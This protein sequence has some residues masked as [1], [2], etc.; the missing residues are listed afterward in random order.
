MLECIPAELATLVSAE[1]Q[2]PTIGIGAGVGCDGQVQVFHDLLGLG[3]DFLPRH[4]RRYADIGA[5]V[6]EAIAAYADDV[7]GA[8]FPGEEQTTHMDAG[9]LESVRAA[10]G[11][12]LRRV[13]GSGTEA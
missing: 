11:R 7:R 13:S 10:R 4:A 9:T 3:G 1:L 12:R 8:A 5:A 6:R 2:V